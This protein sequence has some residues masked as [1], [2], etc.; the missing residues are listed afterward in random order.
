MKKLSFLLLF[1]FSSVAAMAQIRYE[2]GYVVRENETTNDLLIKN[3]GWKNNPSEISAKTSEEAE[4][5]VLKIDEIRE[6]GINGETKYVKATVSVGSIGKKIEDLDK[7]GE[8]KAEDETVLLKVLAQGDASLYQ[9]QKDGEKLYFIS[10]TGSEIEPLIYKKYVPL[11]SIK[12][13]ENNH[14]RQ[15]L[16]NR[17]QCESIDADEV[18]SLRY[19]ESDLLNIF[20]KYNR[21][22]NED[23]TSLSTKNGESNF[24]LSLRPGVR[25]DQLKMET[26]TTNREMEFDQ[27]TSLVIGLQGEFVL[28]FQ[29][30]KWSI[31]A[32]TYYHSY[33]G[34]AMFPSGNANLPD[35]AIEVDYKAVALGLGVRHSFFLSSDSKLFLNASVSADFSLGS[36]M[37]FDSVYDTYNDF[38]FE[39]VEPVF[40]LGGGY[41]FKK[42][43]FEGR[44]DFPHPLADKELNTDFS[45][46]SL[47]VGYQI[48]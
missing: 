38:E 9:L 16:Y 30:N 7:T 10:T 44:I 23:Y 28:P 33:S 6:F 21:C 18:Q 47:I 4:P 37:K 29:K 5:F 20:E 36:E 17:L 32:E 42:W 31:L 41:S 27:K 25:F 39:K 35:G 14:F 3:E 11:R 26:F 24:H 15:Q 12:I 34:E 19:T 8:F 46:Y 45:G 2:K 13:H 1:I 40:V 48:F 22:K 43:S